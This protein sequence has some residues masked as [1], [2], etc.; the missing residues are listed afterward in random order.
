MSRFSLRFAVFFLP[1]ALCALPAFAQNA[2]MDAQKE[3][4]ENPGGGMKVVTPLNKCLDQLPEADATEIRG[5]FLK[6]YQEC[7]RRLQEQQRRKTDK[8]N[9]QAETGNDSAKTAGEEKE[10]APA[11][12]ARNFVRVRKD[13]SPRLPARYGDKEP[14]PAAAEETKKEPA[15]LYNR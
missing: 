12:N 10:P 7:Q 14:S 8:T 5:H 9:K 11:E 2:L 4:V 6:P 13:N 15:P 1:L 3:A